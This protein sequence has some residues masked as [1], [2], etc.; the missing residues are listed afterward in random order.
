MNAL[1]PDFRKY[2]LQI[3]FIGASTLSNC[4][5]AETFGVEQ[6]QTPNLRYV[7]SPSWRDLTLGD[8]ASEAANQ[9]VALSNAV[10]IIHVDERV[11]SW[12][13]SEGTKL[14]NGACTADARSAVLWELAERVVQ[15]LSNSGI[16]TI[17]LRSC[18]LQTTPA[19]QRSTAYDYITNTYVG[20][21][22]D[23]HDHLPAR[24]RSA[25]FQVV[26]LNVGTR[27]RYLDFVN[28]SV[29][30]LLEGLEP[31]AFDDNNPGFAR[32]LVHDFFARRPN[33]QIL[34]LRLPPDY[35]YIAV[36]QNFIHDGATNCVGDDDVALLVA[37]QFEWAAG[38]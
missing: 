4:G 22:V 28:L 20:L 30:G 23:N 32:R 8:V 36:T 6:L 26:A 21:H 27:E 35:A 24:E 2:Q 37:G 34:R 17:A 10:T 12:Y 3:Q 31:G 25:G 7:A 16:R 38:S 9:R 11:R 14:I 13:W 15:A 29:P 5:L 18:D 33:H 19:H 1:E